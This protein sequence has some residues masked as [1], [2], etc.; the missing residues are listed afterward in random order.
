MS[1]LPPFD[2]ETQCPPPGRFPV[3]LAEVEEALVRADAFKGST[4]RPELWE[5]FAT[6]RQMVE[7]LVGSVGRLWI[8]GSFV[9]GKLDPSDVDVTY[10]LEASA[11]Q[12][13]AQ[14]PDD[15]AYLYNLADRE[16][17]AKQGMRVDAYILSLP[18]TEEFA[19]L[20]LTG[21]M[22]TEDAEVFQQ[23]GLYDEIWQRCRMGNG[24]RRGYVEVTL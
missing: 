12:A 13:V 5:Q 10:L 23:L 4:T 7:C 24:R 1:P 17:C 2:P 21:A 19:A 11:Y 9:S 20:G 6:H 16:W 15:V 18:A 14:D 8:A 3:T 22:A